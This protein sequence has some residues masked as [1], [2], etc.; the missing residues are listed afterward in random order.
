ME[1][2]DR[3][4]NQVHPM[5]RTLFPSENDAVFQDDNASI[6]TAGTVQSWFEEHEGEF[7]HLPWAAKSPHLNIIEPLWSVLETRVRKRFPHPTSLKQIEDVLQEE[8]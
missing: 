5:I 2:V 6:H 7:Q 8:Y 4:G 1:Y 3:L